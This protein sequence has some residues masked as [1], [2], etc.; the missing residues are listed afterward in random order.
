MIIT[1]MYV[2]IAAVEEEKTV[3][4]TGPRRT[5]RCVRRPSTVSAVRGFATGP[6]QWFPTFRCV[7]R[8][9]AL[10]ETVRDAR[11]A[12]FVP[13]CT[14]ISRTVPSRTI[15]S[16]LCK[17]TL[18]PARSKLPGV[19]GYFLAAMSPVPVRQQSAIAAA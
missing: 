16:L 6:L 10:V 19:F 3:I 2:W 1:D 14:D 17:R 8:P 15:P 12:V 13:L 5:V 18:A 4:R 11:D 7:P 9:F